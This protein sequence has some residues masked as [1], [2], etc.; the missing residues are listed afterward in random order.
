MTAGE[1]GQRPNLSTLHSNGCKDF[2]SLPFNELN[3]LKQY[4][5]SLFPKYWANP[6]EFKGLWMRYVDAIGK[7]SKRRRAELEKTS[8]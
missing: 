5:F 2:P 7:Y 6:S 1:V 4:M 3:S 8:Y